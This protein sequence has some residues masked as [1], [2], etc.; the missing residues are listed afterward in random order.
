[1]AKTFL[2]VGGDVVTDKSTGRNH[3]IEGAQKARQDF[4]ELLSIEVQSNGFGG[5]LV[6]LVGSVPDS[7]TSMAFQVMQRITSA[8]NRWIGLQRLQR[9]ILSDEEVVSRLTFNQARV[10]DDDQTQ[11]VFRTAILTKAGEEIVR[12]GA[13][14]TSTGA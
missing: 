7:P 1:M 4:G 10:D 8:V 2:I 3:M 9:A 12:G 11:V 13:L 14:S 5:G 6:T